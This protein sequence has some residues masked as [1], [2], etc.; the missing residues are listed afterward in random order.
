[1]LSVITC[2]VLLW[3]PAPAAAGS[4]I[5]WQASLESALTQ[6]ARDHRPILVCLNRAG[7]GVSDRLL[8]EHFQDERIL[9]LLEESVNL[10]ASDGE[11]V[12]KDGSCKRAQGRKCTEHRVALEAV[13]K[14]LADR[15]RAPKKGKGRNPKQESAQPATGPALLAPQ[16]VFL[17]GQGEL[18][19]SVPYG[20]TIGELEWCL[21]EAI[22]R[23]DPRFDRVLGE[24]A[25]A[26]RRLLERDL[27]A[28]RKQPAPL[29]PDA[30]A[31][32]QILQR[33]HRTGNGDWDQQTKADIAGL[34]L[35]ENSQ[36]VGYV[37]SL[38][39][40]R[41]PNR[42]RRYKLTELLHL[43]GRTSPPSWW[44]TVVPFVDD[45]RAEIR[46]EA[47]V[48]LEQLA[49][50]GALDALLKQNR[51]EEDLGAQGAQIRALAAVAPAHK[52]VLKLVSNLAQ[53]SKLEELRVEA[54][55]A[56]ASLE[57]RTGVSEL[58]QAALADESVRVRALAA[59]LIGVRR[60]D[61]LQQALAL[62]R[63]AEIDSGAKSAMEVALAAL[64]RT[65]GAD[66]EAVVRRHAGQKIARDRQ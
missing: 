19:F 20:L 48:A 2:L 4:S 25:R 6:A 63:D 53:R 21:A 62:A 18:L 43:I 17:N 12:R 36:A 16:Q 66:L 42:K 38:L 39:S 51:K 5:E 45:Y 31:V 30:E 7:E 28:A 9:R 27:A 65:P 8:E 26:P 57:Q 33:L 29:P 14:Q 47:A 3:H 64:A 37:K 23:V 22:S 10:F 34:V 35:S 15:K 44:S 13:Q 54:L 55:I 52:S 56:A 49:H 40:R 61:E 58:A 46:V 59:W 24:R 50:P 1:M 41:N 11:H 60:A 32:E